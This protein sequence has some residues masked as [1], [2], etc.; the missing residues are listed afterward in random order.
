MCPYLTLPFIFTAVL[1]LAF[2]VVTPSHA[3]TGISQILTTAQLGGINQPKHS[4]LSLSEVQG[5]T[6]AGDSSGRRVSSSLLKSLVHWPQGIGNSVCCTAVSDVSWEEPQRAACLICFLIFVLCLYFC[7]SR[8][9][10]FGSLVEL[11]LENTLQNILIEA[12]RGEVVLTAR[13]RVI[14]LP[15]SPS[16]R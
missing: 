1:H 3:A 11:V 14:A 4:Y 15:S 6:E 7:P 13:P 5:L 10:A 8:Q 16:R 2:A 9:P 12:S